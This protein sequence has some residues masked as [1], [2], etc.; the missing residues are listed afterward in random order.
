M[1]RAYGA[2]TRDLHFNP[3][4]REGSD[5]RDYY[6]YRIRYDI[7]IHASAREATR[8]ALGTALGGGISIHASARGATIKL[9]LGGMS[10][11]FQS[12]PP[13]GRRPCQVQTHP[14]NA[15]ISIH[16]SAREATLWRAWLLLRM[17]YFNPRLREGG[18]FRARRRIR[19]CNSI[20]IHASAREA[21]PERLR[22]RSGDLFQSTPP[23]G[24]RPPRQTRPCNVTRFISIHAS[25]REATALITNFYI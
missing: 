25:A 15:R 8:G 7:S 4:L 21:T 23:R 16:A 18:D 1:E 22:K 24:R 13:R 2:F 19:L 9:F 10:Y 5:D 3:R 20:S 6:I 11:R 17:E 14:Y 12:T